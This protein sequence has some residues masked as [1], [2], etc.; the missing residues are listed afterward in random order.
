MSTHHKESQKFH[1]FVAELVKRFNAEGLPLLGDQDLLFAV[2]GIKYAPPKQRETVCIQLI[3]LAKRF[4]AEGAQEAGD[5]LTGLVFVAVGHEAA[6]ALAA[7][8]GLTPKA[9]QRAMARNKATNPSNKMDR[10]KVTGVGL[11]SGR[12]GSTPK[13]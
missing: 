6:T 4:Y 12:G 8:G 13:F 7:Q 5:E 11:R 10:P 9:V 3:V 1:P 2:E